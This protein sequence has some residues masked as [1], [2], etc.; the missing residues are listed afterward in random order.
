MSVNSEDCKKNNSTKVT[1]Q[2]LDCGTL[3]EPAWLFRFVCKSGPTS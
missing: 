2:T 1:L 3:L